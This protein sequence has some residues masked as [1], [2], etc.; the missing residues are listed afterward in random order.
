MREFSK[1]LVCAIKTAYTNAIGG[2]KRLAYLLIPIIFLVLLFSAGFIALTQESP[3]Q[4]D[5]F[6]AENEEGESIES[7]EDFFPDYDFYREIP[8]WVKPARWFRSNSG[9]MAI[10][11]MQSRIAALRSEYALVIDFTSDEELPEYLLEY[12]DD[13]YF[14]EIRTLYKNGEEDR[15]Q[16]IF[17]DENGGVRLIAVLF[18]AAESE[19]IDA[20]NENI[21]ITFVDEDTAADND[22]A[23]VIQNTDNEI[24][25][26]AAIESDVIEDENLET[27]TEIKVSPV[28]RRDPASG[29]IEIYDEKYHLTA[30]Y[31]FSDNAGNSSGEKSK[32]EYYYNDS[33][34]VSA[35]TMLWDDDSIE[36]IQAYTDYYRYNRSSFLRAVERVF[37]KDQQITS[38]DDVIRIS[39]PGN[40]LDA[41]KNSLF[42]GEK[43][44]SY[45]EFFG[46]LFVAQD[47]RLIF[48]TD[49]RGRVLEQTLINND[50]ENTV[51]WKI[52]NVWS[53][54]D[55]IL[56]ITK[57][58]GE[59]V[60]LA[61]YVYDKNGERILERN[62]K[63]GALERVVR[64]EGKK[65][66]EE[67]YL[68]N[69][70]VLQAVWEDGR[71]ISESR[72]RKN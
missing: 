40:I 67:L 24:V 65:D 21:E 32:I 54:Q 42:M 28:R 30:E 36:Y 71:K 3:F 64:S 20:D 4:V 34:K 70:V 25:E 13:R 55:R 2:T 9:G 43:F 50:E 60:L 6:A 12:Y 31:R 19:E 26:I 37:L 62:I 41:A 14:I 56:S 35:Q 15:T 59:T 61:E 8:E 51:I 38:T 18:E 10:E 39:F 22:E 44:N 49:E 52:V 1:K 17:R 72:V 66:I 7:D 47:S 5:D 16:W 23:A 46:D 58:E 11:E 27:E 68:N 63:D 69:V 48:T 53:S 29:F 45:P 57:T 33:V